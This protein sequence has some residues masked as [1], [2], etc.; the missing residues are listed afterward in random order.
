MRSRYKRPR[1]VTAA[2]LHSRPILEFSGQLSLDPQRLQSWQIDNCQ[3]PRRIENATD[4][5]PEE[6]ISPLLVWALRWINDFSD[7]ILAAR[8]E[9]WLLYIAGHP[10][11]GPRRTGERMPSELAALQHLLN[12]Y[13]KAGRP[14][15]TNA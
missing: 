2:D 15:P 1:A 9:W 5:T 13:R 4:R 11:K 10:K 6:V 3:P 7:D 14:L 8:D 12:D